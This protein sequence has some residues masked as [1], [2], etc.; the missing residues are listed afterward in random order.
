MERTQ[1]RLR[2]RLHLFASTSSFSHLP[3][4][5]VRGS[6]SARCS[7]YLSGLAG[8]LYLSH[9]IGYGIV[10]LLSSPLTWLVATREILAPT[11]SLFGAHC[12]WDA[13]SGLTF[14]YS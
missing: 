4:D 9:P 1:P 5:P 8:L 13:S 2:L 10:S 6:W 7:L 12:A 3:G 14:W 11:Y